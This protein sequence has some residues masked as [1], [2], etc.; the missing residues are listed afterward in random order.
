MDKNSNS[1]GQ[2]KMTK[3]KKD[4]VDIVVSAFM[5]H[6][7]YAESNYYDTWEDSWNLFNC[8]RVKKSYDGNADLTD[9]MVY[10]SVR[11]ALA[12]IVAGKPKFSFFP[13]RADQ[14]PDTKVLNSLMDFWWD[15]NDMD[16]VSVPWI[17]DVLI[18]GTGVLFTHWDMTR[19]KIF[20]QP[21]RD[22]FVDPMATRP[23]AQTDAR[24]M[25]RRFLASKDEL[26]SYKAF[27]LET[28][29]FKP[30][31]ENVDQVAEESGV[32]D[33]DFDK[34]KKDM[35]MGSTVNRAESKQ[36][37]VIEYWTKDR[38]ITVGN[39]S[40][41]LRDTKNEL[42]CFPFIVQR[43]DIDGSLFYGKGEVENNIDQQEYLND[44]INQSLDNMTYSLN[45]MWRVDPAFA[46]MADEIESVPGAVY[47]LPDGALSV[48]D[49]PVQNFAVFQER[50]AIKETIRETTG[51]D[52]VVKG[53]GQ[54]RGNADITATEVSQQVQSAQTSFSLKLTLL[55]NEG[56]KYLAYVWLKM[57]QRYMEPNSLVRIVG[58]EGADF[59]GINIDE[60]QGNYE[61]KVQLDATTQRLQTE[62]IKRYQALY[63][64]LAQ[65]P[66]IEQTELTK[67]IMERVFELDKDEAERL[68]APQGQPMGPDMQDMQMAQAEQAAQQQMMMPQPGQEGQAPEA[69]QPMPE[70]GMMAPNE[71]Q[72][73]IL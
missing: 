36:I 41:V 67:L 46:D 40:V 8:K 70:A 52:Q 69:G 29:E 30:L 1:Y 66:L 64:S 11:T 16:I 59:E 49:K 19:P 12:N 14:R 18:Y 50:T 32:D 21:L 17:K 60:F 53:V 72:G 43:N 33:E 31:Y 73:P 61:A 63:S 7:D 28:G 54:G 47:A 42:G 3:S 56:Y 15:V 13:T 27:D 25:G 4:P 34:D 58:P 57:A 35:F 10:S 38:V 20:H 23:G 2:S 24:Y 44:L 55:E 48:I 65:N 71:G 62:D 9:P 26:K 5:E 39:R 68:L 6:R 22:F 45:N 51:I 37:E